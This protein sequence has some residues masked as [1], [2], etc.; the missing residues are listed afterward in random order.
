MTP[1]LHTLPEPSGLPHDG[2][3]PHK[4]LCKPSRSPIPS[5]SSALAPLSPDSPRGAPGADPFVRRVVCRPGKEQRRGSNPRPPT[6]ARSST[7]HPQLSAFTSPGSGRQP[8]PRTEQSRGEAPKQPVLPSRTTGQSRPYPLALQEQEVLASWPKGGGHGN[9]APLAASPD[10]AYLRS[11][12]ACTHRHS[13]G[14]RETE[15]LTA[16]LGCR[17]GKYV[18]NQAD[19]TTSPLERHTGVHSRAQTQLC[20]T[21][22][23]TE[24]GTYC[25]DSQRDNEPMRH[26]APVATSPGAAGVAARPRYFPIIVDHPSVCNHVCKT[27]STV[28]PDNNLVFKPL[29]PS[30]VR[31]M[32]EYRR[33]RRRKGIHIRPWACPVGPSVPLAASKGDVAS[34][35]L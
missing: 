18:S 26:Q 28:S 24:H 8:S 21:V 16:M 30:V 27:S 32:A 20:S 5:Q 23:P 11:H 31:M 10:P 34:R 4:S 6:A 33:N 25:Q 1:S 2:P 17:Q 35:Q 29:P 7:H 9:P 22:Q 15:G 19:V 13:P 14:A 3:R 12:N